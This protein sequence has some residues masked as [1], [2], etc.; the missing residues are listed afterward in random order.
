M[1]DTNLQDTHA[2]LRKI[3]ERKDLALKS[4]PLLRETYRALDGTD[5]PLKIRYYQ[6]QMIFHLLA[7]RRF[8]VGDDTGLGKCVTKD[9]L[10]DTHR[11]LVPIGHMQPDSGML[12][13]TFMPLEGWQVRLGGE[14]VPIK[15]FYYGGYK[16]TRR[17]RTR[18]G[19]EVEGSLVHPLYARGAGGEDWR[20]TRE[21]GVGDY[22]CVDR[23]GMFPEEEPS[24]T[25]PVVGDR[26]AENAKAYPVPDRM[27]PA[28]ARLLGYIVGEGWVNNRYSF[29]VSQSKEVN[30]ETH[31][32]IRNL[33]AEVFCR[34][35]A[36]D[37][38]MFVHSV[39]LR[40]YLEHMGVDYTTSRDKRVPEA[41]LQATRDSTREFLRGLFEGEGSVIPGGVEFSTASE[42]L[43]KEVQLLLLRFGIVAKRSP[44]TVEG[45]DHTYWRLT[46]FGDDARL[47]EREIGFVSSRKQERLAG[48]LPDESNPNHDVVP[49]MRELVETLR[50]PLTSK[51]K[52]LGW[53]ISQRWGVS[54]Y[55]TLGHIR[56]G[57]RNP[58]YRFLRELLDICDELDSAFHDREHLGGTLGVS[59]APLA[60][61]RATK[62]IRAL[63][64]R[65][66]FYDPVVEVIG[67]FKEIV[68]IEVDDPRHSFVGNGLVNHNTLEVIAALCY[69]WQLYPDKK[70]IILTKKSAVGQFAREFDKFTNAGDRVFVARGTPKQRR[71]VYDQFIAYPSGCVLVSGYRSMVKDIAIVQDWK[72][73]VLVLDE[74]FQYH[75]PVDLADGTTEL[76]GKIV[77]Q[78]MDVE[79]MSRN[80][81]TGEVE[82][83]KVVAWHRNPLR[84][85]RRKN[86]L[87]LNFRFG[88]KVRVTRTHKY[89]RPD[90][91]EVEAKKLRKRSEVMHL[92][93]N[94]PTEDQ[95][96]VLLG[97]LLGDSSILHP[98]RPRWGVTFVH[99]A[100]QEEYLRFKRGVLEPLGVSEVSES[101]DGYQPTEGEKTPILRFNLN[102][103]EALTSFLE[104]ARVRRGGKKRVTMDWL[105]RIGPLGLAVWYADDGSLSEHKATDGVIT[106]NIT[107][108]TQGFTREEVEF[109]AGWLRWKWSIRAVVKTTKPR[110]DR[111]GSSQQ[112]YPYL[113]LGSAAANR[114]LGLLP[115]GFPGVMHKFPLPHHREGK[116]GDFERTPKTD[117]VIDWVTEKKVWTPPEKENYVYNLEVEGN[118]NYFANG[119]LVSNCTVFKSPKTQVHQLCKL[120]SS[121]ADRVWGLTATLIKN[122]L[123]EGFG[124]YQVIVPGLF[125]H[126]QS[127]F[128]KDYCIIRM[129]RVARGRQIPVIVGYRNRD[130]IRFRDK[131]DPYYL[132][133]PKHEVADELPI[134][135]TKDI[136][137]GMTSFQHE[138]YQEALAGLL[139]MGDGE[140]KETDQ[141]TKIIYC[142]EIANH[143][144]LI[145]HEDY[146]SEKLDVLEDLLTEGG[147]FEGEKVIVF[148]RFRKMVDHA[149][150][151]L[152][153]K[154][155]KCVRVTGAE[156]DEARDE[157]M[158]AF[159]DHES[160]VKVIWIT[161]AGG[162][163]INLQAAKAMIFYDTPWSAGDYLQI[164]GRMI[165]IGSLHDRVYAVRLIADGTVDERV[166]EVLAKKM[167]LVE[168]IL[169]KRIKGEEEL[170]VQF[171]AGS[172]TKA[173]FEGLREDALKGRK[174]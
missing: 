76:I 89:F 10:I 96:Q 12:P 51:C 122:N 40:S 101:R 162:D 11:G 104:Q 7:M 165:R 135:T 158:R 160:D 32:D 19:F 87:H 118:H 169:G 57:R 90:G 39:F 60:R 2:K 41:V 171:D 46:L 128:M 56:H 110:T 100:K 84:R 74:C 13:D 78:K 107:L 54:F 133:R 88:G 161:M 18:Y 116:L 1:T 31:R 20:K 25:V 109:L 79:V 81:K 174:K 37:D 3:R 132:G 168:A 106:R 48:L 136:P 102:V 58:T 14:M 150:P 83:R 172:D 141:L 47:F 156:D 64:H 163:A 35:V 129:Q 98:T 71:R 26:V 153:K 167:K 124:I 121:N 45:F 145:G 30:P 140:L 105:D 114:F 92:S 117:V 77:T 143:P 115:C 112:S 138:K 44:K 42:Q 127:S 139:E 36:D 38:H 63:V 146:D 108:N 97:G 16:P 24:L 43:G 68:D 142:Q 49:Y 28:L 151:Y 4:T 152:E 55:N 113:Y 125:R 137:V 6:V 154:G 29:Q 164:L 111:E 50:V 170:D 62:E 27:N 66:Y 131:I 61:L 22:L 75:T 95:W 53:R 80:P 166:Q 65:H 130:I 21:I 123:M 33:L 93:R 69:L 148:T 157:A 91:G 23:S 103:N 34:E 149:M 82:P 155:I 67:G 5:Q 119:T 144:C 120:L 52:A 86:L 17:V 8:I 134:L 72:D 126:T 147:D 59:F 173:I 15:S 159:Q 73:F 94:V 99:S 9:T 70:A 85:G